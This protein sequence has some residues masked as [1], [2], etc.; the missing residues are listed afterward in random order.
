[1]V[2]RNTNS[3]NNP[4]IPTAALKIFANPGDP[5]AIDV[6]GNII[7]DATAP[8]VGNIIIN[9]TNPIEGRIIINGIVQ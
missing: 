4:G 1:M 6:D 8:N 5:T 3:S 7:I 9:T 2:I